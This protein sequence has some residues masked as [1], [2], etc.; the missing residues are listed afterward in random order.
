MIHTRLLRSPESSSFDD[1]PRLFA[2]INTVSLRIAVVFFSNQF[3]LLIEEPNCAR[4]HR[5]ISSHDQYSIFSDPLLTDSF[6]YLRLR[7]VQFRQPPIFSMRKRPE[8]LFLHSRLSYVQH[9]MTVSYSCGRKC[10]E[11]VHILPRRLMNEA[12][13]GQRAATY[14]VVHALVVARRIRED[15]SRGRLEST[16]PRKD[17]MIFSLLFLFFRVWAER[18]TRG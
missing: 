4:D 5:S 13:I 12:F 6:Q 7:N 11:T 17:P 15:P 1:Q 3:H 16:K 2:T 9:F 14:S 8:Q 10:N 18:T